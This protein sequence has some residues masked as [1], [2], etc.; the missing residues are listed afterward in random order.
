ML[1]CKILIKL[2]VWSFLFMCCVYRDTIQAEMVVVCLLVVVLQ[3]SGKGQVIRLLTAPLSLKSRSNSFVFG[4][5]S[6]SV[7]VSTSRCCRF[8]SLWF[9]GMTCASI[10]TMRLCRQFLCLWYLLHN[11]LEGFLLKYNRPMA[12]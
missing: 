4:H 12:I 10:L 2:C 11:V 8:G 3:Y 9:L 6:F 1:K 7:A 5:G